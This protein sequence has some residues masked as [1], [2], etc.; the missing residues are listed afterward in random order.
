MAK[1]FTDTEK[2]KK[3]FIRS[4]PGAYKLLW[5][6]IY[7]DCNHAGV[8][9][10]DFEIAQIYLGKDLNVD[11]ETA[12]ELFN[13]DEVRVIP[14]AN[15]KKWFVKSFV[16]FQYGELNEK[17]KVHASVIKHLKKDGILDENNNYVCPNNDKIHEKDKN[18]KIENT[19][20]ASPLQGAKDK[21]KEKDMDM[22]MDK[23]KE[24]DANFR[25]NVPMQV[26]RL[27][28]NGSLVNGVIIPEPLED[29]PNISEAYAYYCQY[30]KE[31]YNRWPT[32]TTTQMDLQKLVELRKQGND[33]VE[34]IK[35]TIHAKNKSFYP[36]RKEYRGG[37]TS[38]SKESFDSYL[39]GKGVV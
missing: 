34:V 9:I 14:F 10:A 2:Y 18:I 13:T 7:H 26:V 27:S 33:P 15:G 16:D 12:L 29:V 23:D 22:D 20:L 21:D 35:Q 31:N 24:K 19:D 8:W 39:K 4:L 3:P 37:S 1:R 32:S 30:M 17:N 38:T 25:K 36:I 5:D 6:Y 11:K 28:E